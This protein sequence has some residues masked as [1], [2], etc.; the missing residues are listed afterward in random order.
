MADAAVLESAAVR[1]PRRAAVRRPSRPIAITASAVA[2]A[3]ALPAVYLVIRAFDQGPGGVLEAVGSARTAALLAR[4]SLLA[5]AVTATATAIAVPLAWLTVRTDVPARRFISVVSALPLVVPSYV[6][7]YAF[8]AALG[9]RGALQGWLAPLG[10]ERLP[11]IYGFAGAWLVLSLFTYPLVLLPTR[12][13]LRGLDPAL[14]EIARSLGRTPF[15]VFVEVTIPQLRP[16]AVSGGLLVALYTLSDFGAVSLMRFDTFTREIYIRARTFDATGA[17]TLGLVLVLLMLAVLWAEGRTRGRAAY[18]RSATGPSRPGRVVALGAWRWPALGA[19]ALPVLIALGIPVAV[20]AYWLWR[21]IAA[22]EPLGVTFAAAWHSLEASALAAGVGVVAAWPVSFLAARHA[23]PF[24]RMI[25]RLSHM[26][27]ALPGI[28]VAIALSFLGVRYA[29]FLYQSLGM[30]VFAYVVLFLPQGIAALRASL[31][32]VPPSLEDAAR[33]LGSR[34][35]EVVRRVVWPLVRP[36]AMT[37]AA[38][39][40]LTAMKELPATLLLAPAEFQTLATRVWNATSGA[41]FTRAAAPALALIVL[42]SFPMA[43]LVARERRS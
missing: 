11:P 7:G 40:F 34:P 13:A 28:V 26:G 25:E 21:G 33:S 12:A 17:A 4:T 27:Y 43:L 36:G 8:V 1:P 20:I 18:H 14:E 10:V 42:S 23:G 32:Q 2:I 9:P 22:G 38:L 15:R 19:A 41:F 39:I 16:A 35:V 6:G 31:L 30:L 29:F 5:L 24:A 3:V 37:G